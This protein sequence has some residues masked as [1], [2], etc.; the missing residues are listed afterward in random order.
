MGLVVV[1][2]RLINAQRSN[3]SQAAREGQRLW[4]DACRWNYTHATKECNHI[5]RVQREQGYVKIQQYRQGEG[6]AE[7][8]LVP[9]YLTRQEQARPVLGAQPPPTRDNSFEVR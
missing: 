7:R 4:C 8:A 6:N 3:I 9:T 2:I 1:I 5:A